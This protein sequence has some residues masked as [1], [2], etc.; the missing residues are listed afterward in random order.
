MEEYEECEECGI[1]DEVVQYRPDIGDVGR[2]LCDMCY[3][4]EKAIM[5]S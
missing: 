1:C 5:E 4:N 3:S 2:Y